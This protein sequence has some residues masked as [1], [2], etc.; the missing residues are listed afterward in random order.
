VMPLHQIE[1]HTQG[2]GLLEGVCACPEKKENLVERSMGIV[3]FCGTSY[4]REDFDS[5][6]DIGL[7]LNHDD[8]I[9]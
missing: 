4:L 2:R 8:N 9:S 7:P 5:T 3:F 1:V 6:K